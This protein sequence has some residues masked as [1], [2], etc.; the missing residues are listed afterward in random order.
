M[1]ELLAYLRKR[2]AETASWEE[3]YDLYSRAG[4]NIDDA[5][6]IGVSDGEIEMA[7]YILKRL[8][9]LKN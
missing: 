7:R 4:G 9:N 6:E 1:D 2:A 3:E 5:Y 8:D